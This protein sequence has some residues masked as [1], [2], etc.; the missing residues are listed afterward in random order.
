M[1]VEGFRFYHEHHPLSETHTQVKARPSPR[2]Y[3]LALIYQY[4]ANP[5]EVLSRG[6]PDP[7]KII[8][9]LRENS[10]PCK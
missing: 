7:V 9:L 6:H 2:M 5:N 8:F 10:R 1:G 4:S 3:A